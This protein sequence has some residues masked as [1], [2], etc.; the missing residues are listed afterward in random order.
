[1]TKA[2]PVNVSDI[3]CGDTVSLCFQGIDY[4]DV[5]VQYRTRYCV[6]Y[7]SSGERPVN[8]HPASLHR[9]ATHTRKHG[10]EITGMN[11]TIAATNYREFFKHYFYEDG[12]QWGKAPIIVRRGNVIIEQIAFCK[13]FGSK[14]QSFDPSWPWD[15]G[16]AVKQYLPHVFEN[17]NSMLTLRPLDCASFRK[18]RKT[19]L[20]TGDLTEDNVAL[21][22]LTNIPFMAIIDGTLTVS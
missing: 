6:I 12:E 5:A 7:A 10:V 17:R 8:L 3:R 20:F 13:D 18:L 16:H 1:M 2:T 9:I 14:M 11:Y 21:A 4:V 15:N 22:R 19:T